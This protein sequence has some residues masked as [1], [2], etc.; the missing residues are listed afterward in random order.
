MKRASSKAPRQRDE[1]RLSH[2]PLGSHEPI[3]NLSWEEQARMLA[4]ADQALHV[5]REDDGNRLRAGDRAHDDHERL[6]K[7]LRAEVA[8]FER[9]KKIWQRLK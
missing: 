8:R 4:L 5:S 1:L 7:E 2:E 3:S 9:Q 6:K